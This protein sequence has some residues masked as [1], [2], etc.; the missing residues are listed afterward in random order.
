MPV[1][2]AFGLPPHLALGT[3]KAQSTFGTALAV[4]RYFKADLIPASHAL[5]PAV[6]ATFLAALAGTWA[7]SQLPKNQ[8][9]TVIPWLLLGIAIYTLFSPRL[10]DHA[11]KPKLK[12]LTFALLFGAFLGFYD[13]FFGPGTGAFWTIGSISMLGLSLPQATAYTKVVNL[14]SNI[15]AL[16]LFAI[17]GQVRYDYAAVMVLGQLLGAQLGSGLAIK[18]GAPFIRPLFITV[19]LALVA[20]L[21]WQSFTS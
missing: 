18:H 21:L 14:T 4:W 1:L 8:L 11:S 12:P 19:V 16:L 13:G 15:A 7:V 9:R 3:N 10:G 17:Y 6:I 5:A 2:L 20:R